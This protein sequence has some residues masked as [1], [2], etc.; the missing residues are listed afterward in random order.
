MRQRRK[1]M[2]LREMPVSRCGMLFGDFAGIPR[3]SEIW[4]FR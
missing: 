3:E 4:N 1:I 2:L